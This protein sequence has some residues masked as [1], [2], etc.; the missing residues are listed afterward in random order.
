MIYNALFHLQKP[1][2]KHLSCE[3]PAEDETGE[4]KRSL[5]RKRGEEWGCQ[6][7]YLSW[8]KWLTK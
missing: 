1:T 8:N 6:G 4:H 3:L 2:W 5:Y 7:W